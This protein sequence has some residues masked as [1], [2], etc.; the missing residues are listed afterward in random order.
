MVEAGEELA[1]GNGFTVYKYE[2]KVVV[3]C[4]KNMKRLPTFSV[5]FT[6]D[7]VRTTNAWQKLEYKLTSN[8]KVEVNGKVMPLKHAVCADVSHV[9]GYDSANCKHRMTT[10]DGKAEP[11]WWMPKKENIDACEMLLKMDRLCERLF[12]LEARTSPPYDGQV[13]T[14][15]GVTFRVKSQKLD[16]TR[17]EV[18]IIHEAS[19]GGDK[20]GQSE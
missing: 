3:A 14:P 17:G 6:S 11:L 18:V 1:R 4:E 13:L 7:K 12:A 16:A 15:I 20:G 19:S 2:D 8:A 5:N 10:G 9:W